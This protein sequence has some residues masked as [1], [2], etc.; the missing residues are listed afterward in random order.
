M[1][2]EEM[3]QRKLQKGYSY[4]QISELSG[5]PLGT[6]QKIF[7]GETERPRYATLQALEQVLK[8]EGANMVL[9]DSTADSYGSSQEKKLGDYTGADYFAMPDEIRVELIDGAI[10][11]MAAPVRFTGRL[12]ITYWR[13][14]CSA[15]RGS[16]RLM[17]GLTVMTGRWCSRIS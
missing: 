10:Y 8:S 3:K 12:Q 9:N 7:S 1:T 17:C 16:L 13:I 11:D 4:A 14:M 6:V 5:V 2:I 15:R